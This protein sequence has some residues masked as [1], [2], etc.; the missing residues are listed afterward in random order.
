VALLIDHTI[1]TNA[2]LGGQL[3]SQDQFHNGCARSRQP[4]KSAAV[5]PAEK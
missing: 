1:R 2:S 3:M 4:V 5:A